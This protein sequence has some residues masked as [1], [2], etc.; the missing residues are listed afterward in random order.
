MSRRGFGDGRRQVAFA[1]M[2]GVRGA[3]G[4]K[5]VHGEQ[6][7]QRHGTEQGAEDAGVAGELARAGHWT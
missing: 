5:S 3:V 4:G 2:A 7:K 6:P 1:D